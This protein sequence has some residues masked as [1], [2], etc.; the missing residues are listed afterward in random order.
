MPLPPSQHIHAISPQPPFSRSSQEH[1]SRE[2]TV[3]NKQRAPRA[4][5]AYIRERGQ[6]AADGVCG[7]IVAELEAA[8]EVLAGEAGASDVDVGGVGGVHGFAGADGCCCGEEGGEEGGEAHGYW[9]GMDWG[10]MWL[11]DS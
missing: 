8:A 5:I 3:T 2:V 9:I 1:I 11:L 10:V 6:L 4:L 7:A